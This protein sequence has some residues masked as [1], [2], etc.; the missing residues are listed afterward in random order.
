MIRRPPRSTLSSSS[1]ASDVYKR[2]APARRAS[3]RGTPAGSRRHLPAVR[4]HANRP[5]ANR[6]HA[7][8]R[9]TSAAAASTRATERD[10]ASAAAASSAALTSPPA[11]PVVGVE[12]R[13]SVTGTRG[14]PQAIPCLLYTSDA[15]DEEDSVDLG[16]RRI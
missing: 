12:T 11:I 4:P 7:N 6:P 14:R 9:C 16:G 8:R 3:G 15:A 10:A 13:P 5:H 2:Q 1:A